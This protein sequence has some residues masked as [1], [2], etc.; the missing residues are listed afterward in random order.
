MR[1][2][3]KQGMRHSWQTSEIMKFLPCHSWFLCLMKSLTLETGKTFKYFKESAPCL[4]LCLK[5]PSE[6]HDSGAKW[7]S[8]ANWREIRKEPLINFWCEAYFALFFLEVL[9]LSPNRGNSGEITTMKIGVFST[10]HILYVN[11]IC[12]FLLCDYCLFQF[13]LPV[14]SLL[15][16]CCKPS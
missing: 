4:E 8:E 10:S 14:F 1:G 3:G 7:L 9:T 13:V 6:R 2:Q 11:H 12:D 5:R 16:T 15:C